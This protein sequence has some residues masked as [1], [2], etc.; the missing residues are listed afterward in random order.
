MRIEKEPTTLI[1]G[2]GKKDDIK[3]RCAQIKAR[4]DRG[5]SRAEP[6]RVNDLFEA[7]CMS[8]EKGGPEP[9]RLLGSCDPHGAFLGAKK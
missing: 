4:I 8:G 2:A 5:R 1:D 3:G 7:G 9:G 6:L